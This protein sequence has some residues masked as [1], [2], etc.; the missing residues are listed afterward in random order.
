[1][2]P[3]VLLNKKQLI[4]RVNVIVGRI[5]IIHLAQFVQVTKQGN[6]VI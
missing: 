5:V 4:I 1:M 6:F 2:N 3:I